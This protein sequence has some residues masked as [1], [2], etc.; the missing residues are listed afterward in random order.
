MLSDVIGIILPQSRLISRRHLHVPSQDVVRAFAESEYELGVGMFEY[1]LPQFCVFSFV[2]HMK[3][4]SL[5]LHSARHSFAS[6]D[7]HAT[8]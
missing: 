6:D 8:D 1:C 4:L 2:Q 3:T 7:Q 5:F